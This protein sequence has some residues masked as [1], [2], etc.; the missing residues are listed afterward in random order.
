MK[1][2]DVVVD[3]KVIN[4]ETTVEARDGS[5]CDRVATEETVFGQILENS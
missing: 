4:V 3:V 5:A 2:L 1:D